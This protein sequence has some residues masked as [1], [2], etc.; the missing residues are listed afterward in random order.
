MEPAPPPARR[1][2][3]EDELSS[4]PSRH[5]RVARRASGKGKGPRSD[6]RPFVFFVARIGFRR[7]RGLPLIRDPP[8]KTWAG[9]PP[10][11][12]VPQRRVFTAK[13]KLESAPQA[14]QSLKTA[15]QY[16]H[17]REH[18]DQTMPPPLPR[19]KPRRRPQ[20]HGKLRLGGGA[21]VKREERGVAARYP[22]AHAPGYIM[23]LPGAFG[24]DP[25]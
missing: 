21:G 25:N 17:W 9:H 6:P 18:Q 4:G 20:I 11:R 13:D 2:A 14:S 10:F 23:P 12:I 1:F 5:E 16:S 22:G 24:T 3:E 19:P 7:C 15:A 8:T